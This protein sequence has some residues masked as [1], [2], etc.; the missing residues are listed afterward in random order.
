MAKSRSVPDMPRFATRV[1]DVIVHGD[2]PL[3]EASRKSVEE[4]VKA[5]RKK[6]NVDS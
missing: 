5:V 3:S 2:K 6:L 4:I 1:G